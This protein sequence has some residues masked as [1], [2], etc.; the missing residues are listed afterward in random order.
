MYYIIVALQSN[1]SFNLNI[2]IDKKKTNKSNLNAI[3]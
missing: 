2:Y 3:L 1:Q